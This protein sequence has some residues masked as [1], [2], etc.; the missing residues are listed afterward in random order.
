MMKPHRLGHSATWLLGVLM[1]LSNS[2]FAQNCDEVL[3]NE[4][5]RSYRD[6]RFRETITMLTSCLEHGFGEREKVEGFRLVALSHIALDELELGG[7]AVENLLKHDPLYDPSLYDLPKFIQ[8]VG[9]YRAGRVAVQV[10]SVSK[11]AEDLLEAPATV[12]VVTGNEIKTRGYQDLI[13]LLMDLP[14]FDVSKIYGATYANIY[15]RGFRQNNSER[16]LFLIDGVEENDL[17]TNIAYISRQ[18]PLTNIERVEVVY[19]PASTMYGA[20][21]FVG[22]IN[23][24]TKSAK[25][26]TGD[27]KTLGINGTVMGGSYNSYMADL[28]VGARKDNISFTVT[29]R[30]YQSDEMDLSV[31]PYYDYDKAEYETIDYSGLLNV[32]SGAADY[33]RANG[34]VDTNALYTIDRNADGDT[35]GVRLT[36]AGIQRAQD[37]DKS[38]YDQILKWQSHWL[39]EHHQRLA[40]QCEAQN[41]GLF[42]GFSNMETRR[43]GN[44]HFYGYERSRFCQRQRMGA[45]VVFLLCPLRKATQ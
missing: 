5:S 41:R 40:D 8:M 10:T 29:G 15:Q 38:G 19:G 37:L 33:V 6:G 21:A 18:Y 23:V 39:F 14:G 26:L 16:T 31:D 32:E 36:D 11:K 44:S 35:V 22:V 9:D 34:L 24:I 13:D 28:T 1:L 3:L 7:L 43:R 4:A 45:K 27:D 2:L 42:G 17:W 12:M 20:N 25:Q 30:F